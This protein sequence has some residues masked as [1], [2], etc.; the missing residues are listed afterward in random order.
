MYQ[1]IPLID[2]TGDCRTAV[3]LIT[4]SLTSEDLQVVRSF[5]L[6]VAR[7]AHSNCTCPN[8]GTN[9]CN[10]QL[11]VLLVYKQ[12]KLTVTLIVHGRDGETH[13]SYVE[14]PNQH[15]DSIM[16]AIIRH[17]LPLKSH[18]THP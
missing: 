4:E 18:P 5:D 8:H 3:D 12:D 7:T 10:C 17:A 13:L 2:F 11:V 6:Q 1:T 9:Q 14:H 16:V 15:P